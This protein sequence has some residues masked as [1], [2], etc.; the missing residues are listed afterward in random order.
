MPC[1]RVVVLSTSLHAL[2]DFSLHSHVLIHMFIFMFLLL[3]LLLLLL[4]FPCGVLWLALRGIAA[5]VLHHAAL[6]VVS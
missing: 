1:S 5:L 2:E 3:L 4:L 6:S